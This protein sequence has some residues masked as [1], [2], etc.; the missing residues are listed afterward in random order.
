MA[1][2]SVFKNLQV[3]KQFLK[4]ANGYPPSLASMKHCV[5]SH[6]AFITAVGCED[7]VQDKT[8]L[9]LWHVW[10]LSLEGD[11]FFEVLKDEWEGMAR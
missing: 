9:A 10:A 11:E 1:A 2:F 5:R 6:V 8:H 3:L 4:L 7:R